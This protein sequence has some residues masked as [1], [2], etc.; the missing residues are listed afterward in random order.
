YIHAELNPSEI[1]QRLIAAVANVNT[2]G[3]FYNA[4][5]IMVHLVNDEGKKL[6]EKYIQETTPDVVILDPWQELITGFNENAGEHTGVARKF[7]DSLIDKYA[8][9]IFLVQHA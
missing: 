4:R 6:I 1:K 2:Q 9:T 8:V 3:R 7:M 5:D